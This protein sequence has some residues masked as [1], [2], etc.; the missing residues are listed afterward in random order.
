MKKLIAAVT[1]LICVVSATATAYE[2]PEPDWGAL[3]NERR[4]MVTEPDFDLY[5]EGKPENAPYYGAKFEPRSGVYIG[6]AA[7]GMFKNRDLYNPVG[8]YLTYIESFSRHDLYVDSASMIK[9]DD[10]VTMV[11][12]TVNSLDDVNYDDVRLT[13]EKL[14]SYGKPMFIRFANEMNVSSIGDDPGRYI[15]IFRNVANIAHEYPNL[16]VVWS[17]N[18]MGALDRPFEYYYPGDEYIDW[19]GVCCYMSLY[20]NN[21][22]PTTE[23]N[24]TYFMTGDYAWATNKLKPIMKFMTENNINKPVMISE[25][26]VARYSSFG[27]DYTGW[28]EPRLRN[29]LWN[30]IM[31]YPQIKMINYFNVYFN[32]YFGEQY[33]LSDYPQSVGIF[34]EAAESGA[35]LQSAHDT[36]DFVFTPANNGETLIADDGVVRLYTLAYFAGQPNITV[37]YS[38]DGQWFHCSK[39]I[40]YT[41]NF[42]ITGI[43]DGAHTLTISANGTSRDYTLYKRGQYMSFG[44]EPDTTLQ[45]P[46]KDISV[47]V[48]DKRLSFDQPPILQDGRT[49]VPLRA[50]FEAL[51]ALVEWEPLTQTITAENDDVVI[52]LRIGS[53]EMDRNSDKITLDVPPMIIGD[54]T[55]V[56]VRAIAE[57]FSCTVDWSGETRTVSITDKYNF[58]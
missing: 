38:I 49:L 51:G 22:P 36:P 25:G 2:F 39:E 50:I 28:H 32:N 33:Y 21:D 18:D 7:D 31:K 23:I 35:Y 41:C 54:R 5:V 9:S 34:N 24:S 48:N 1:A 43:T 14:N 15:Q 37:D 40:P 6:M 53:N 13:F 4:D 52:T 10:V 3:L 27:D 55:L 30:V 45:K 47:Y 19:I 16:A 20:F 44:K 46:Q 8:S 56:P 57:A 26:G 58:K 17:P 12:W 42:D 29:M 11:G